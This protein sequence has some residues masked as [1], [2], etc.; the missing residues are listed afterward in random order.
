ML[1]TPTVR[2]LLEPTPQPLKIRLPEVL[3]A[4]QAVSHCNKRAFMTAGWLPASLLLSRVYRGS[5]M[6]WFALL[7]FATLTTYSQS[8]PAGNYLKRNQLCQR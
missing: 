1:G 8:V 6:H 2:L 7:I 3:Q 4:A 5:Q